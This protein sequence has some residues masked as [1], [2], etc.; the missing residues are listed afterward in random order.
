MQL[1]RFL[2]ATAALAFV[3]TAVRAQVTSAPATVTLNV[4]QAAVLS[5]VPS[6]AAVVASN[7][8]SNAITPFSA[9][10]ITTTWNQPASA[11]T[12]LS[13]IGYFTTADAL[14]GTSGTIPTSRVRAALGAA[15][16]AASPN[17]T[18]TVAG[19]SNAA[20][21]LSG[22]SI[23]GNHNSSRTDQL[24]IALDYSSGA[25]APTAGAYTGTLN[26]IAVVQ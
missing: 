9:V 7:P 26:L 11:G 4:T 18:S 1:G 24:N 6:A 19:Q 17:F 12:G 21:L 13:I 20:T 10:N 2:A 3:A 5:I 14:S 23:A 16:T 22:F 15:V 8:A 25:T